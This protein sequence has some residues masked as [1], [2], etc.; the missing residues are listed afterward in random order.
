MKAKI[1]VAATIM[2]LTCCSA[3]QAQWPLQTYGNR[4]GYEVE[5]GG[6]IIDRPGTER[7]I[8]LVTDRLTLQTL[9][10]AEQAS[11]LQVSA[12]FDFRFAKMTCYDMT[13]EVRGYFQQWD[14]QETLA[15]DLVASA[16]TPTGLP[17][18]T[19][20]T[21]F[22][23]NYDSDLAS[24]ELN[25]KRAVRPG[26]TLMIG[27]RFMRLNETVVIDTNF[28]NP[29]VPD[30]LQLQTRAETKNPLKGVGIAAEFRRPLV[31]DLFFIGAIRGAIFHNAASSNITVDQTL[32][33]LPAT[34]TTLIDDRET[35]AAGLG[36]I[37]ARLHYDV[38][39]GNVSLYGGYEAMWLDGVA[40]APA[41][42]LAANT[43]PMPPFVNTQTTVFAHGVSFGGMIRY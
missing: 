9:F 10:N 32:F 21:A 29:V 1:L 31:R 19:T 24:V 4:P 22:D 20:F 16:F 11:D 25:F 41:Q 7:N 43:P 38:I 14:A 17:Q 28:T 26:L 18:N 34:R 27:P 42:I 23:Y 8:P 3:V 36:E 12:G 35:R 2:L 37:T 6:R 30:F 39:P 33:G 5:L 15:G 13:W 40:L